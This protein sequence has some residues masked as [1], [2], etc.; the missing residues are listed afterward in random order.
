MRSREKL[1]LNTFCFWWSHVLCLL[2][3]Y[4]CILRAVPVQKRMDHKRAKHRVGPL[5]RFLKNNF[6]PLFLPCYFSSF[7]ITLLNIIKMGKCY[8][9]YKI[10]SLILKC[11]IQLEKWF[12]RIK[13][14]FAFPHQTFSIVYQ[15]QRMKVDQGFLVLFND[16]NLSSTVL[17][18]FILVNTY[19]DWN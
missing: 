10:V 15:K 7:Y 17:I 16:L 5:N 13:Q 1:S 19:R 9:E 14:S 18:E 12:V 3:L 6:L 4:V 8:P 2:I 11:V